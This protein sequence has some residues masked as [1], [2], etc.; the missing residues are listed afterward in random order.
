MNFLVSTSLIL[1]YEVE[2]Q[3]SLDSDV[4]H[5]FFLRWQ[6]FRVVL[7]GQMLCKG[8]EVTPPQNGFRTNKLQLNLGWPKLND[9][10]CMD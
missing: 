3:L 7:A 4:Q 9:L 5:V 1:A 8:L 6:N 2:K 10:K